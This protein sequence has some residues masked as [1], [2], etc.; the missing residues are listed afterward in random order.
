MF[1]PM[2]KQQN[3]LLASLAMGLR[4]AGGVLSPDVQRMN[5]A[6]QQA[7]DQFAKQ[8]AMQQAQLAQ[9]RALAEQELGVRRGERAEDRAFKVQE[10]EQARVARAQEL[11]ERHRQ[12]LE[13][14]AQKGADAAALQ[15]ERLAYQE[16]ARRDQ[17]EFR[18][19]MAGLAG[20]MR[21]E[22]APVITE[23]M[24][25]NGPQK[26]DARTGRV[27]GQSPPKAEGDGKP[28]T[29]E[30]RKVAALGVRLQGALSK[31]NEVESTNPGVAKPELG[32]A[33]LSNLPLVGNVAANSATS[34]DRQRIEAAQLDALDA[35][36]TL[37]T[38]AAYTEAQ[39]KGLSKSY[40][41]QIGDSKKTVDEKRQR[42]A[43]IV[44]AAR[45]A[46]GRAEPMINR[47]LDQANPG[48]SASG[49]IT[50]A[51]SK[52]EDALKKYGN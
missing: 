24:G 11:A 1:Q 21:Q 17:M 25:P 39:L 29:G 10:L 51:N 15:A 34:T 8:A 26:I 16:Q 5:F 22:P 2:P 33:I 6:E 13:E 9:Q 14:L 3:N 46:S 41:P 44:Q 32:P 40:F 45:V 37:A 49:K 7:Q 52:L 28:P 30:E 47:A 38:G 19:S 48:Q 36:L 35:A 20:A 42:F 23:V 43:T 31:I 50:P 18:R 27:I 12:R 4:G